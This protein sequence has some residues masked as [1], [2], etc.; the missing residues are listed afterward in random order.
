MMAEFRPIPAMAAMPCRNGAAGSPFVAKVAGMV[1]DRAKIMR[2]FLPDRVLLMAFILIILSMRNTCRR[3]FRKD[4]NQPIADGNQRVYANAKVCY[5]AAA[6]RKEGLLAGI[7]VYSSGV[8]DAENDRALSFW[9]FDRLR[10][11]PSIGS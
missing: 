6:E 7:I 2:K 10:V 4:R 11:N 5:S 3:E 8:D 9:P 1:T